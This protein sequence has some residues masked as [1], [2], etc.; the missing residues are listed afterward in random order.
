MVQL[1]IMN[2]VYTSSVC[3]HFSY[4]ANQKCFP[5]QVFLFRVQASVLS[6]CEG[7]MH[8]IISDITLSYS[9]IQGEG[10]VSKGS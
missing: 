9:N 3:Y 6:G 8:D 10:V 1:C 5:V 7:G 4:A 2:K